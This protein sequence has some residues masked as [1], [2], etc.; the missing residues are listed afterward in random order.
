MTPPSAG[1]KP[2]E[3]GGGFGVGL[4]TQPCKTIIATETANLKQKENYKCGEGGQPLMEVL[5]QTQQDALFPLL[6]K[7][8]N[9]KKPTLIS[10]WKE[11]KS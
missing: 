11:K 2:G 3:K 9:A 8:F 7:P 10:T 5:N 1:P 4:A 6:G